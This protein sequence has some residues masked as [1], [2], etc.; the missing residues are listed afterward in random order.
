MDC[1]GRKFDAAQRQATAGS[2]I[3]TLV[4]NIVVIREFQLN[5]RHKIISDAILRD[6][7]TVSQ[8]Q[9]LYIVLL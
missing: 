8:K 9:N 1:R 7:Y 5:A 3:Y 4:A 6:N 2:E